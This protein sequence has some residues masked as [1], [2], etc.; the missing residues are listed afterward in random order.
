MNLTVFQ[1]ELKIYHDSVN[2]GKGLKLKENSIITAWETNSHSRVTGQLKGRRHLRRDWG[3]WW[4]WVNVFC[5]QF[6]VMTSFHVD[7][8]LKIKCSKPELGQGWGSSS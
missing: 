2:L 5:V 3:W 4:E 1:R 7:K 8:K 6:R